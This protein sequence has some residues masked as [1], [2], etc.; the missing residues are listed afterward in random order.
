MGTFS[1]NKKRNSGLVYEFLVRNLSRAM[2]DKDVQTYQRTLGLIRKYYS[3][4]CPMTEERELFDVVR[5]TRGVSENAARRILG[6]IQRAALALD[7]KKINIKKSNL[8]KEINHGLGQS[9][10]DQNRVPEYRLLATVQMIIDAARSDKKLTESIQNIQLEEALVGYMVSDERKLQPPVQ[11]DNVDQLV[12][13]LT[14]KR[15]QEKYSRALGVPQ[16]SLLEK[17]IRY[18]VTGDDGE[19]VRYMDAERD[20]IDA[21]LRAA[22]SLKEICDDQIMRDKLTEA[23]AGFVI[24]D[25][26]SIDDRVEILMNY[27]HLVEEVESDG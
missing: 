18:Q 23:R 26:R 7:S 25:R 15:F 16:K 1:H 6:E 10:W 11:S 9:F 2:I 24:D 20:R 21:S 19:L 3:P 5:N 8:I 22:T 12:M 4:G 17:F 27:Q 13:A 14:A